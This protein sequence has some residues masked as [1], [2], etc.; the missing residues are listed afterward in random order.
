M[1]KQVQPGEDIH[2]APGIT[3]KRD[4]SGRLVISVD[5]SGE[6]LYPE[7]NIKHKI[8]IFERQVNGWF[9]ERASTLLEEEDNG[10]VILM[11][12]TAYVE[13]VEQYRRGESSKNNSK[14]FFIEGVERIF[15]V[16]CN[17]PHGPD[18]Y[19]ELRCGLFHN[20]MTGPMIRISSTYAKPIDLSEGNIIKINQ[21]LFLEKVMDDFN[22]YLTDL[23]N[24]D[25]KLLIDKFNKMYSIQ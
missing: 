10:F 7:D 9:L 16:D 11:I 4:D 3:G 5:S 8:K 6:P 19:S 14:E 12:S 24:D 1:A 20:G 2:I 17:N 13:G 23:R 15:H 25:N 18:F 21:N 22:N